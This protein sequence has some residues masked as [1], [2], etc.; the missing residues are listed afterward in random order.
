MTAWRRVGLRITGCR[1]EDWVYR[2]WI[3]F[4]EQTLKVLL[5][6]RGRSLEAYLFDDHRTLADLAARRGLT[7]TELED[8]LLQPWQGQVDDGRMAVLRDRTHRILTQGHLAQHIFFHVYHGVDARAMAPDLFRLA[9]RRYWHL[10][11]RRYSGRRIARIG[12]VGPRHVLAGLG[13]SFAVDRAEGVRLQ[14]ALPVE[15]ER[16]EARRIAQLPCWFARPITTFDPLAPYNRQ[17]DIHGEHRAG[18]PFTAAQQRA[19]GRR[20]ER[21]R[22]R[23]GASC[24]DRPPRWDPMPTSAVQPVASPPREPSPAPAVWPATQPSFTMLLCQQTTPGRLDR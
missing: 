21:F 17:A 14:V 22:A 19:D 3:P 11:L 16:M 6:L 7:P 24:Y 10:R 8:A 9:P 4:D 12:G 23:L 1:V 5:G 2:H 20:I 15:A 18:Y 13:A